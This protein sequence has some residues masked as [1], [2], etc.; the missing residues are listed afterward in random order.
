[1][2]TAVIRTDIG[3]AE[4]GRRLAVTLASLVPAVAEGVVRDG[5]ILAEASGDELAAIADAAGCDL[6]CAPLPEA[7]RRAVAGAA[8]DW[9]LMLEAGSAPEPGWWVEAS[10]F[11]GPAANGKCA[12]FG[13][14]DP[15]YSLAGRWAEWRSGTR[16]WLGMGPHPMQ[17]LIA[18]KRAVAA[19]LRH[20]K[21]L[22]FPP[23]LPA[24][25][26]TLRA[27]TVVSR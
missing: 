4:S 6:V 25:V 23:R 9:L 27:R 8:G 19:E 3:A 20:E 22:R 15:R 18:P 7:L 2:L 16:R 17:G 13:Y 11:V 26:S 24:P 5:W 10:Q 12:T 14:A 21:R 1:M